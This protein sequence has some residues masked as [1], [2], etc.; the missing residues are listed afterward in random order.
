MS[1]RNS[2]YLPSLS[3]SSV[4]I[5]LLTGLQSQA[6]PRKL[7]LRWPNVHGLRSDNGGLATVNAGEGAG[8]A[9]FGA[10][11]CDAREID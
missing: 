9:T 4:I 3:F 6:R 8:R 5:D 7:L 2:I 10:D 11:A 1:M